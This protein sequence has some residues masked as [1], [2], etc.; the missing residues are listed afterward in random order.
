M[1]SS[2]FDNTDILEMGRYDAASVGSRPDVFITGVMNASLKPAGKRPDS[3]ERLNSSTT[4]TTTTTAAAASVA[5]SMGRAGAP[6][7]ID[8]MHFYAR[9][10]YCRYCRARISYGD[11]VRPSVRLSRPGTDSSLVETET[12]GFHRMIA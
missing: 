4:T 10:Q 11:S 2:S 3:S 8:W 9:Q 1:R 6:P 12:L 5:D 7:P